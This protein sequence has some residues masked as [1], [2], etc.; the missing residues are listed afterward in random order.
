M[1]KSPSIRKISLQEHLPNNSP[2]TI[3]DYKNIKQSEQSY[4]VTF[5][6]NFIKNKKGE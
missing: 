2:S 1:S 4:L 5:I 3:T 6:F